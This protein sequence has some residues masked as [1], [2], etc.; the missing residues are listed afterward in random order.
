MRLIAN[1]PAAQRLFMLAVGTPAIAGGLA[2]G[3]AKSA[4]AQAGGGAVYAVT[5]LDVSTD[6][7]LQ[8]GGLIKQY[9][10]TS[11]REPGNLEFTVLQETTRPNRFAV[12]EGWSDQKSMDAYTKSANKSVAPLSISLVRR[13]MMFL[14]T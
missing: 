8:G 11:R 4:A 7:I 10:D 12:V 3:T 13:F 14:P 5:Y 1:A 9:R 6:W 2:L